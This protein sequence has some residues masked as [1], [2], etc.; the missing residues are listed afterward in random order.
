MKKMSVALWRHIKTIALPVSIGAIFATLAGRIAF[1]SSFPLP[2][3]ESFHFGL[4]KLYTHHLNPFLSSQPAGGDAYG[5][6]ARDPSYLYQYLMS[7]PMRVINLFTQ[8][9]ITQVHILRGMNIALGLCTLYFVYCLARR[10]GLSKLGAQLVSLGVAVTPVFY[11]VAAQINYDNLFVPLVIVSVLASVRIVRRLQKKQVAFM[12]LSLTASLIIFACLVKFTYL[13]IALVLSTALLY[14]A[15]R[16]FG[17]KRFVGELATSITEL[18][19]PR[20]MLLIALVILATGCWWQRYGLNVIRYHTPT[21]DCNNVLSVSACSQYGVWARNEAYAKTAAARP[22]DGSQIVPFTTYWLRNMNLQVFSLAHGGASGAQFSVFE[23]TRVVAK[24]ILAAGLGV[25]IIS[26]IGLRKPKPI[27]ILAGITGLVYV[28]TLWEHNFAAYHTLHALA[29][30]QG[31]YLLPMIPILYAAAMVGY[32]A[33]FSKVVDIRMVR[34]QTA[35]SSFILVCLLA[36]HNLRRIGRL[37]LTAL[38]RRPAKPSY[39]QYEAD[40]HFRSLTT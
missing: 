35:L 34:L 14:V 2:Y 18:G 21:P 24:N 13:P 22:I 3:D 6:V 25:A 36:T 38:T 30:I 27:W 31:R 1:R 29:G 17:V 23:Q 20:A 26:A 15:I 40:W 5:A 28:V 33:V 11:D 7:F 8:S 37:T 19:K 4:I 10:L 9:Q 12:Q 16:N 32:E 39:M